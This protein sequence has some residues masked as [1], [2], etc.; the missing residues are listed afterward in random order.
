M[1]DPEFGIEAALWGIVTSLGVYADS[2]HAP[3]QLHASTQ[4]VLWSNVVAA[5]QPL[6]QGPLP[7]GRL[8]RETIQKILEALLG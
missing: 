8:H 4:L 6:L 3:G 1:L 2:A 5:V 7:T